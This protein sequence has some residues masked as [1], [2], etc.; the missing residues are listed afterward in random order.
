M[1]KLIIFL[2]IVWMG[3]ILEEGDPLQKISF[4]YSD[5]S[6]AEF[7]KKIESKTK[8]NIFYKE[9][10]VKNIIVNIDKD[11]L[12]IKDAFKIIL[13]PTNL[14]VNIWNNGIII[15]NGQELLSKLP[16]YSSTTNSKNTDST[17]NINSNYLKIMTANAINEIVIG[18]KKATSIKKK[19]RI[20]AKIS[21]NESGE[22][23]IGATIY[24]K[25]LKGAVSDKSGVI[26]L[27]IYPGKYSAQ[28][29]FIGYKKQK[30]QLTV[31]SSG[32][33]N[34][35]ME[36]SEFALDEIAIYADKLIERNP[37]MERIQVKI[38]KQIPT[39]MG[40]VD[41]LKVSEML[42]GIV[43]VGEG[44]SGVNV[45]GGGADQ[46]AFYINKIPILN[47]SHLFGFS[48]AFNPD[49]INNFSIYK[50][51]IPIQ[52]GGRL[53]SV[54]DIDTRHGNK[55]H[56]TAH[57]GISPI[58]ANLVLESPIIKDTASFIISGRTSYSDWILSRVKDPDIS[59]SHAKFYD[60]SAELN[61][62]L[63]KTQLALFFYRSYD[64]FSYSNIAQYEYSSDGLALN[65]SHNFSENIRGTF[66]LVG[67]LYKFETVDNSVLSSAYKQNF[68]ITQ[69]V[70]TTNI[71]HQLSEKHQ[72][73]YGAS[74]SFFNLDRGLVK[75]YGNESIRKEINLGK[76]QG[77]ES[78]LYL[79][80]NFKATPWLDINLGIRY[81]L[82]APLGE[83]KVYLYKEGV[84]KTKENIIDSLI[85]GDFEVINWNSFPEIRAAI[86]LKTDRNGALK[87]AFNQMHQNLFMLNTSIAI[88]PNSQWKLADYYLKPATGNQVSAGIFRNFPAINIESSVEIYY[89]KTSNFTEF[90]DGADFLNTAII[91]TSVLQ[92]KQH[93]YGVELM[94]KKH[95]KYLYGWV[96]YTYSRSLIQISGNNHWDKINDGNTYPANFDIP[97]SF[98]TVINSKIKKRVTASAVINYQTGKPVTFPTSIYFVNNNSYI[99]YSARNAYRIPN[100]FRIDLSVNIEG[101]LKRSKFIH[102]SWSLGVYNLTGRDNAYSVFFTSE[103]YFIK[104]YQY[105]V[106][107]VPIFTVSW[108]FK[109]GNYE[110]I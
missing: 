73:S 110:S 80:E 66:S 54:F 106:I 37:G 98:T 65:V 93:A 4:H 10:W 62:D 24:I 100:Y 30:C 43:S 88:A 60:L 21:D 39:M 83:K 71:T 50:G 78:A 6:F 92:G 89:T 28:F 9:E 49:I 33:F 36:K 8:V 34:I 11:S 3:N 17:N 29:E 31:N 44:S 103:N 61:Y 57:G 13:K 67:S 26:E 56:F 58:A 97:H 2:N 94:V 51:Y 25:G 64:F 75:P 91:E 19:Q 99:D 52:F 85:F 95:G 102:S 55:N 18:N 77:E 86:H 82:Y 101:N 27:W 23:L 14:K 53:A 105:S 35:K 48:S 40:E 41:V 15:T 81:S 84:E 46:N 104:G 5:I 109:L 79:S 16:N 96:S 76:E 108:I 59:S 32:N 42:P 63:P 22:I 90:K 45:R 12:T 47:T 68:Q 87:F 20:R 1:F 38:I 107:S 69:A 72:L 74:L 7:C 70:F